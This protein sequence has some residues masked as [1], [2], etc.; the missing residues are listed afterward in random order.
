MLWLLMSDQ[1]GEGVLE[2]WVLPRDAVNPTALCQLCASHSKPHT[3]HKQHQPPST[4][5]YLTR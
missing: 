1:N 4:V 2:S 5:V 3:G